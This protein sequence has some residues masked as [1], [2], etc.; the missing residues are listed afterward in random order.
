MIYY[1]RVFLFCQLVNGFT[2]NY[3]TK[4]VNGFIVIVLLLVNGFMNKNVGGRGKKSPYDSTHVRVPL[5]IKDRVEEIKELY[6]NGALEHYDQLL[7][8]D[9]EKARLYENLL[10]G[11]KDKVNSSQNPLPSLDDAL[12]QA[13]KLLKQKKSAKE[14][15]AKLLT[16]LYG[17]TIS[18]EDL[19]F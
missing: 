14:T 2:N 4:A 16:G 11:S 15:I 8:D 6:I 7:K 12:D 19:T 10:T 18:S 3:L 9:H 13:K 5:P 1:C 17:K